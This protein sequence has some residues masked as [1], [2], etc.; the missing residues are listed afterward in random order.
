MN[1]LRSEKFLIL[2]FCALFAASSSFLFWQNEQE[3]DPNQG[4]NWW[5]LSFATPEDT[6]NIDF[7]IENH[8]RETSFRYQ[9]MADKNILEEATIKIPS[10]ASQTVLPAP[11]IQTDSRTTITVTTGTEKKEIYR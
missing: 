7:I 6:T 8:S 3:L 1:F 9:I 2:V 10:G 4:K 5:T 11:L